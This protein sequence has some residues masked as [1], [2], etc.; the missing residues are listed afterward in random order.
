MSR[1]KHNDEHRPFIDE[2]EWPDEIAGDSLVPELQE[3]LR[4]DLLAQYPEWIDSE[5]SCPKCDD[6]DRRFAE[7][8]SFFQSAG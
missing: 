4:H 7:L 2:L 3:A 6:Y 1:L 5:G 8:I